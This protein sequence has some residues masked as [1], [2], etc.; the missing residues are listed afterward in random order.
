[1]IDIAVI[2]HIT[3]VDSTNTEL[4]RRISL[5]TEMPEYMAI[6]ADKQSSGHGRI[7]RVWS[8]TD[9]ALLMSVALP[10]NG[11]SGKELPMLNYAAAL[12]V[13]D[14]ISELD[15][16]GNIVSIEIKWP[17]DILLN[18]KKVC[19]ILS[20]LVKNAIGE[21]YAVIGIGINVNADVLPD[22]LLQSASSLKAS[23]GYSIELESFKKVLLKMLL[24]RTKI[25]ISG[26][27][28]MLLREYKKRC[29]TLNKR[30]IVH[31][32]FGKSYEAFAVDLDMYGRLLI[33]NV[34]DELILLDSADVSIR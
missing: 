28:E 21:I 10:T 24:Q 20:E 22:E 33:K 26:G 14:S 19:G 29:I 11:L 9:G 1:M 23:F 4:K 17:N 7:G 6:T 32:N 12:A 27:R 2:E 3:E 25:L 8:N 15:S 34:E 31:P 30:I 18:G 13:F 16:I 5:M